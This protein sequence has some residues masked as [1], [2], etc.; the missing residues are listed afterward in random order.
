MDT[1]AKFLKTMYSPS[2]HH[3]HPSRS[4]A[5]GPS[6]AKP[7]EKSPPKANFESI[8]PIALLTNESD[9]SKDFSTNTLAYKKVFRFNGTEFATAKRRVLSMSPETRLNSPKLVNLVLDHNAKV[10][11][12]Q[13]LNRTLKGTREKTSQ[14]PKLTL[15]E[16]KADLPR[17][18]GKV[19]AIHNY[20]LPQAL[21]PIRTPSPAQKIPNILEE[22]VMPRAHPIVR[23]GFSGWK[24]SFKKYYLKQIRRGT[25]IPN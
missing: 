14:S 21:V 23:K 24:I 6:R 13:L 17:T 12:L 18:D 25:L 22:K 19:K 5:Q 9:R 15:T 4:T 2:D 7:D 8:L 3:P 11:K 16:I 10:Q 20:A 1:K